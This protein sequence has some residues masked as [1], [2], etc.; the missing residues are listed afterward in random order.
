MNEVSGIKEFSWN[1]KKKGGGQIK[2]VYGIMEFS[3]DT[4]IKEDDK[5]RLK[6]EREI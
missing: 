1:C 2:E 5:R 3:R 6:S 4:K